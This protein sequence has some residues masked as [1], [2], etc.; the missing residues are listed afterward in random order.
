MRLLPGRFTIVMAV[1][2]V[3]SFERRAMAEVLFK[4]EK[5]SL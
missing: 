4:A 1:A 5:N 3:P 2:N